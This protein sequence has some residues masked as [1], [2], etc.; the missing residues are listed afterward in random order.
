VV[1][2]VDQAA[3]GVVAA[4]LPEERAAQAARLHVLHLLAHHLRRVVAPEGVAVVLPAGARDRIG[5]DRAGP[6]PDHLEVL[7]AGL[8]GALRGRAALVQAVVAARH[9]GP[10]AAVEA[11][12]QVEL[13]GGHAAV[14]ERLDRVIAVV[15]GGVA[16]RRVGGRGEQRAVMI[17]PRIPRA[18]E[19]VGHHVDVV[20]VLV[21][22]AGAGHAD[23]VHAGAHGDGQQQAGTHLVELAPELG[24]QRGE[25]GVV[26]GPPARDAAGHR[27][28]PVDVDAVEHARGRA[29]SAGAVGHR[30]VAADVGVDARGNEGLAV[31]RTGRVG[32]AAR[33]GPAAQR[34]QHLQSGIARL[35]LLE[36]V[37]VAAQR[38][39]PGVGRAAHALTGLEGLGVVGERVAACARVR[40]G[41]LGHAHLA[42]VVAD[43]A[44][45]V[46]DVG[47]LGRRSAGLDVLDQVAAAVDAPLR[48]VADHVVVAAVAV[49]D[50]GAGGQLGTLGRGVAGRVAGAHAVAVG[51]V[52][53]ER[54]IG[55]AVAGRRTNLGAVAVHVI[56][57]HAAAAW[58]VAGGVPRQ[59]DAARSA[60]DGVEAGRDAGRSHVGV[61]AHADRHGSRPARCVV[62]VDRKRGQAVVADRRVVPGHRIGRAGV[63]A[64]RGRAGE[65]LHALHAAVGVAG[66][67]GDG[68]R[69]AGIEA[70]AGGGRG[71]RDAGRLVLVAGAAGAQVGVPAAGG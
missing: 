58:V 20:Q 35:E 61:L 14:E 42:A 32:E 25:V 46:V 2:R 43:V 66:V 34:D 7:D 31:F 29:R 12:A 53:A 67:G 19:V 22:L 33:P 24:Q 36:L 6:V 57:C 56:A 10:A 51:G 11:D 38:L 52:G 64:E 50:G 40:V 70:G 41:R 39:V 16:G 17:G 55:E 3:A 63:D 28:F 5:V 62:V 60:V 59:L 15:E 54:G 30:Q 45:G 37:P 1:D 4:E 47:Q 68:D 9:A 21:V 18:M 65:E 26:L 69:C 23:L 13:G 44:E 71:Q 27:V 48:E 49:V 8:V